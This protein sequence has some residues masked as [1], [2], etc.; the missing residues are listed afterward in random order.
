M[1][2]AVR[3]I[4]IPKSLQGSDRTL[5]FSKEG[6]ASMLQSTTPG[7]GPLVSVPVREAI[8]ANPSLE[9]SFKFMFPFGHPE[10]GF[11]ERAIKDS[12]PTYLKSIDDYVRNSHTNRRMVQSMFVDIMTQRQL[13]G[14]PIDLG[15]PLDVNAVVELANTRAK[16]FHVFRIA[17]GLFSPTSATE[18][19]PFAPLMKIA[20]DLQ[21]E[22][23][24]KAGNAIFLT[25]YGEDL[26]GLTARMTQLNDGVA[27]SVES[28][29]L[30][31]KHQ[32]LIQAFP[33][34]GAWVSNSLGS[35]DE[36]FAFSQA[37]Y[38]RQRNIEVSPSDDRNRRER[39]T[40]VAT[41]SGPQ[42]D[43][44]WQKYTALNDAVR[45]EQAKRQANGLPFS[46]N[47]TS[48]RPIRDY[49]AQQLELIRAEYPP[50]AEQFDD[51]GSSDRRMKN[52]IDGFLA[53]LENEQILSRPSTT[54]V[55]E[56]FQL[57]QKVQDELVRRKAEGG[58][59]TLTANANA[60]LLLWF[61]TQKAEL[62][63]RNEFSA[64]YD[65]YFER[66]M[67]RPATFAAEGQFK[68]GFL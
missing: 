36:K 2:P 27:A 11:V 45:T 24:T 67:I 54:H 35:T 66:D 29:E 16:E 19:S 61:E 10:G 56:Y 52:V 9:E 49:K 7:V 20:R 44:G 25:D 33:D 47:A 26:F 64:I 5:R 37:A 34:I 51:F 40:P 42:A 59:S 46:L 31:M 12:L 53:G 55:I 21:V 68:L 3:N 65:R 6:L 38:R 57:R 15:D 41:V 60:E 28:E 32:D 1:S 4:L 39:K 22:H 14:D 48:M 17:A 63:D 43:L 13:A 50:F 30:Y 62:G 23:G 58:S 18:I 8:L